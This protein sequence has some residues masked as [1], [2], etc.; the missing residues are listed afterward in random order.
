MKYS[1][2]GMIM[3]CPLIKVPHL[4]K[5]QKH[6]EETKEGQESHSRKRQKQATEE[7]VTKVTHRKGTMKKDSE[8]SNSRENKVKTTGKYFYRK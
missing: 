7:D 1:I 6:W 2:K 5:E 4:N 3:R 8:S